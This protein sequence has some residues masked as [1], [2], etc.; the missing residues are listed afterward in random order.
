MTFRVANVNRRRTA[1]IS[2]FLVF[3]LAIAPAATLLAPSSNNNA[4]SPV[5]I[6]VL[7]ASSLSNAFKTAADAFSQDNPNIRV[8]FSFAGSSTL[9]TQIQAGSPVDV[10]ALA[11]ETNML[12]VS[13]DELVL[14]SSIQ[15]LT[16]NRLAIITASGNPLGI[17]SLSD[18]ANSKVAVALCDTSQPCGR[19]ADEMFKRAKVSITPVSRESS[20][21]GVVSRV[22]TGEADAGIAYV[23]DA[24]SNSNISS[25]TIPDGDN[26]VA[27]Y[28]IALASSPSSGS[29]AAAE[30]FLNFMMSPAGQDILKN[31]GFIRVK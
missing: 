30:A 11:D 22:A 21:T 16:N 18:L 25:V 31:S 23:S 1:I 10:V 2:L 27:D 8:T 12:A 20:V 3:V 26:I 17:K 7:A 29:N 15:T 13:S 24:V 4:N 14:T 28:P 19:Y 6:N 5:T 9:V